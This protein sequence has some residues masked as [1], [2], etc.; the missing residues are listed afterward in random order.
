M[1]STRTASVL[2]AATALSIAALALPATASAQTGT[3][4]GAPGS[5]QYQTPTA[6]MDDPQQLC[7]TVYV[8]E[9]DSAL[10]PAPL[11]DQAKAIAGL[12][13]QVVDPDG[14]V[15][16]TVTTNAHGGYCI[17]D[18]QV[19]DG[20]LDGTLDRH[21]SVDQSTID[22]YNAQPGIDTLT[23]TDISWDQEFVAQVATDP[24]AMF[25]YLDMT[26]YKLHNANIAFSETAA[27]AE[28]MG[29]VESASLQ[30]FNLPEVLRGMLHGGAMGS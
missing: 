14:T 29:S 19:L 26:T 2:A 7:G 6:A 28:P 18:T 22:A 11:P 9:Y 20:N 4:V 25:S 5:A 8:G 23:L 16:H 1:T 15:V 10:R 12:P 17:D 30:F 27:P 21:I 13:V 3:T 24:M